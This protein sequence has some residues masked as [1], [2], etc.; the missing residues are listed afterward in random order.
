MARVPYVYEPNYVLQDDMG[1]EMWFDAIN[2]N[3]YEVN[4]DWN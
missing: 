2:K 1:S 3:W 4:E